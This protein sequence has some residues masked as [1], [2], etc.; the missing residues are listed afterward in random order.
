MDGDWKRIVLG[1]GVIAGFMFIV[2]FIALMLQSS[3]PPELCSCQPWAWLPYLIPLL[4]S[5]GIF[6]GGIAY[7]IASVYYEKTKHK[8]NID[9]F[10]SC[11]PEEEQRVIRLLLPGEKLQSQLVRETGLSKVKVHRILKSL[12]SRGVI[13]IE[14]YGK[15]NL[16]KLK[17]E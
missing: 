17:L 4:G 12:K 16:V 2:S 5:L 3:L 1:V 7:Y 9:K 14:P 6:V 15:T 10:L 13:E 11:L 8:K